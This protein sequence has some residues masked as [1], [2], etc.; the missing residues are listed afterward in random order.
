MRK[1]ILHSSVS[2]SEILEKGAVQNVREIPY[3]INISEQTGQF[4]LGERDFML[5]FYTVKQL[6]VPAN[7]QDY[8]LP[9][10]FDERNM[11]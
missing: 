7:L 11:L 8:R 9:A 6:E 2:S 3:W 5:F 10:F 4:Q 1:E